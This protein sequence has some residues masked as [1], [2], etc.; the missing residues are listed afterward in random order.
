MAKPWMTKPR[1]NSLFE[2]NVHFRSSPKSQRSDKTF[3][4]DDDSGVDSGNIGYW[5]ADMT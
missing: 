4:A 3:E 5:S 2:N 1:L